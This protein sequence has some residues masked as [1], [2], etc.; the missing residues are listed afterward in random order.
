MPCNPT[1]CLIHPCRPTPPLDEPSFA[2]R[3]KKLQEKSLMNLAN[4][5]MG[6]IMLNTVL[7]NSAQF[8]YAARQVCRR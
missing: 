3:K 8:V 7:G 4:A 6:D 1:I 5:I 2:G